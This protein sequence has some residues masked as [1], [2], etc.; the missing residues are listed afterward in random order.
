MYKKLKLELNLW[1][2]GDLVLNLHRRFRQ[3][4]FSGILFHHVFVDEVQDFTQAELYLVLSLCRDPD[5]CFLAGD[6]A[7][8]IARGVG[9]RFTDIK[10]IFHG[11]SRAVPDTFTLVHNYRSH[12]G[13]LSLAAAVVDVIYSYFP[14]A[15]DKLE[16]DQGLFPG[17]KPKLLLVDSISNLSALLLG[18]QRRDATMGS[19]EFGAQ[20]VVLVRSDAV[21]SQMPKEFTDSVIVLTVFE[22]KGL[23]FDDVLLWNFFSDG[24]TD[25]EWRTVYSYWLA[26]KECKDVTD[27]SS[28]ESSTN[29]GSLSSSSGPL[30]KVSLE[31]GTGEAAA[32]DNEFT[33]S[34]VF[35]NEGAADVQAASD[36]AIAL[37][38]DFDAAVAAA[39]GK[40]PVRPLDFDAEKHKVLESELKALY[41]AITRARVNVWIVD[42]DLKKRKPAFAWFAESSLCEVVQESDDGLLDTSSSASGSASSSSRSTP[43]EWLI[44]G[45]YFLEE[46]SRQESKRGFYENAVTC[47]R[48]AEQ[49][50]LLAKAVAQLAEHDAKEAALQLSS[51]SGSSGG[52]AHRAERLKRTEVDHLFLEAAEKCLEAKLGR[53][54]AFCLVQGKDDQ[55]AAALYRT[56]AA[57][58]GSKELYLRAAK[59][60]TR[61]KRYDDSI[62]LLWRGGYTA[63]AVRQ[64]ASERR[65]EVAARLLD[66][67]QNANL[68]CL[69]TPSASS[70]VDVKVQIAVQQLS[71][72]AAKDALTKGNRTQLL[73][74]LRVLPVLEQVAFL[75]SAEDTS[76]AASG[77]SSSTTSTTSTTGSGT[78]TSESLPSDSTTTSNNES[79]GYLGEIIAVLTR[80]GMH[81][82]AAAQCA[83][84]GEH[85]RG[86]EVLRRANDRLLHQAAPVPAGPAGESGDAASSRSISNNSSS[87]DS[88]GIESA[89][90]AMMADRGPLLEAESYL[91]FID[92]ALGCAF[93]AFPESDNTAANGGAADSISSSEIDRGVQHFAKGAWAKTRMG[94]SGTLVGLANGGST[95]T[96]RSCGLSRSTSDGANPGSWIVRLFDGTE[97]EVRSRDLTGLASRTGLKGLLQQVTQL[98]DQQSKDTTSTLSKLAAAI[99]FAAAVSGE[100]SLVSVDEVLPSTSVSESGASVGN[101]V[102]YGNEEEEQVD[103][104]EE[105]REDDSTAA[106]SAAAKASA[107][108]VLALVTWRRAQV[109][110]YEAQLMPSGLAATAQ[111]SKALEILAQLPDR[112]VAVAS[113]A[114]WMAALAVFGPRK[115]THG[116]GGEGAT[117]K[118]VRT[119]ITTWAAPSLAQARAAIRSHA[120]PAAVAL[121]RALVDNPLPPNSLVSSLSLVPS[122]TQHSSSATAGS[123]SA[124]VMGLVPESA[125]AHLE[126]VLG[127]ESALVGDPSASR[128]FR[129]GHKLLSSWAPMAM[130]ALSVKDT[131]ASS[132]S[133]TDPWS[134]APGRGRTHLAMP[135]N[136]ARLSLSLWLACSTTAFLRAD[137]PE[138]WPDH[139]TVAMMVADATNDSNIVDDAIEHVNSVELVRAAPP[140]ST[141]T[142]D[143]ALA[144]AKLSRLDEEILVALRNEGIVN[145]EQL[146]A[147]S[148]D[149]LSACGV[150]KGPYIK[151]KKWRANC[152]NSA[153]AAPVDT[154]TNG[155]IAAAV[156]ATPS[157]VEASVPSAPA[158]S[159][160]VASQKQLSV[161]PQ[162]S[163]T[164]AATVVEEAGQ[165][166]FDVVSIGWE[167]SL[168][169]TLPA[170]LAR[171]AL[172]ESMM[173]PMRAER[174]DSGSCSAFLGVMPLQASTARS[175]GNATLAAVEAPSE[176]VVE[177]ESVVAAAAAVCAGASTT[178]CA[179]RL[180]LAV[181]HLGHRTDDPS[182]FAKALSLLF[183]EGIGEEG[184]AVREFD[185]ESTAMATTSWGGASGMVFVLCRALD[186]P[187]EECRHRSSLC[188]PLA[189]SRP[190]RKA[191]KASTMHL[192][193]LAKKATGSFSSDELKLFKASV[194]APVHDLDL[195]LLAWHVSGLRQV[196]HPT[197]GSF[198]HDF[199]VR[200]ADLDGALRQ[201][202]AGHVP[203]TTVWHLWRNANVLFR[204]GYGGDGGER[205]LLGGVHLMGTLIDRLTSATAASVQNRAD[206][207][208]GCNN[209][210]A[211]PASRAFVLQRQASIL[212]ALGT[213]VDFSLDTREDTT[214]PFLWEASWRMK[215]PSLLPWSWVHAHLEDAPLQTVHKCLHK[216]PNHDTWPL[217]LRADRARSVLGCLEQLLVS[218]WPLDEDSYELEEA[219]ELQNQLAACLRS[220]FLSL[221]WALWW[222]V[223]DT[224]AALVSAVCSCTNAN[225]GSSL[226]LQCASELLDFERVLVLVLTVIVNAHHLSNFMGP[227]LKGNEVAHEKCSDVELEF[228][229]P[230]SVLGVL[231]KSFRVA[232]QFW[233]EALLNASQV[234]HA[235]NFAGSIT[236][237]NATTT[238]WA[239]LGSSPVGVGLKRSPEILALTDAFSCL[240]SIADAQGA[241][242]CELLPVCSTHSSMNPLDMTWELQLSHAFREKGFYGDNLVLSAMMGVIEDIEDEEIAHIK[243]LRNKL[244]AARENQ[245][246]HL[247]VLRATKEAKAESTTATPGAA[248]TAAGAAS[249]GCT[250]SANEFVL[251]AKDQVELFL[252][253]RDAQAVIDAFREWG[254][255]VQVDTYSSPFVLQ[256]MDLLCT[257]YKDEEIAAT[258]NLLVSLVNED[259]LTNEGVASG[260]SK[261]CENLKDYVLDVPKAQ[262]WMIDVI[263]TLCMAQV[264]DLTWLASCGGLM[265][266]S[267]KLEKFFGFSTKFA[268]QVL[269]AIAKKSDVAT[270]IGLGE[271][272]DLRTKAEDAGALDALLRE[273]GMGELA[274]DFKAK[275]F[276][277][278]YKALLAM[279][280]RLSS[281][282]VWRLQLSDASTFSLESAGDASVAVTVEAVTAAMAQAEID[283]QEAPFGMRRAT[284]ARNHFIEDSTAAAVVE[285]ERSSLV[286]QRSEAGRF[287][288]RAVLVWYRARAKSKAKALQDH[289]ASGSGS[290]TGHDGDSIAPVTK[291]ERATQ[292]LADLPAWPSST[293]GCALCG[294]YWPKDV[295]AFLANAKQRF[296]SLAERAFG[297]AP[298]AA[299]VSDVLW[300]AEP[301]KSTNNNSNK[302]RF[303]DHARTRNQAKTAASSSEISVPLS[304]A[305][306]AANALELTYQERCGISKVT[307]KFWNELRNYSGSTVFRLCQK[308]DATESALNAHHE[309][310]IK[311][312]RAGKGRAPRGGVGENQQSAASP[313][314]LD[315]EKKSLL[316]EVKRLHKE[317]VTRTRGSHMSSPGHKHNYARWRTYSHAEQGLC[318][319]V[320]HAQLFMHRLPPADVARAM[321]TLGVAIEYQLVLAARGRNYKAL[322]SGNGKNGD[323]MV[324][325]LNEGATHLH[326][327][328]A[329][330]AA[331][332]DDSVYLWNGG[333]RGIS[334]GENG[335]GAEAENESDNEE[336]DDDDGGF[337][338]D[339]FTLAPAA[340]SKR[341]GGKARS[342]TNIP[343]SG[344]GEGDG[345]W[346]TVG[347][348]KTK[349]SKSSQKGRS[350][351]GLVGK[352][353]R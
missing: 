42:F 117:S 290:V 134:P 337:D 286:E 145:G 314:N 228:V 27:P 233:Q 261:F 132:S 303:L 4:G 232:V 104:L 255:P 9:F 252:A 46:A 188:V 35:V 259:L 109:L 18:H 82:E 254:T 282:L 347:T 166:G 135:R 43:E 336:G 77:G 245:M 17:P 283:G 58:T 181:T 195:C 54:A 156:V 29:S 38:D 80:A 186:R 44:R 164:T 113:T 353:R 304:V 88:S 120:C 296:I 139:H 327:L 173:L 263:S 251:G 256:L 293:H 227:P 180:L 222:E 90:T 8:T 216:H 174:R 101:G 284:A 163:G 311:G 24:P 98:L 75:Q 112:I 121:A 122:S 177:P 352:P 235:S 153:P 274:D 31:E 331:D 47:F 236:A 208:R 3:H 143:E 292:L 161:H 71:R 207:S 64:A 240:A 223:Q 137:L 96:S 300:E 1:D 123:T 224:G 136:A 212:M 294:F 340:A 168:A 167:E 319:A 133:P 138:K 214:V 12:R 141:L 199:D 350:R 250:L 20:Q 2:G 277:G 298:W 346:I 326:D 268:V 146:T 140:L 14:G 200:L 226:E 79:V 351:G 73:S 129:R 343:A 248:A 269:G 201:P 221:A 305:L 184:A 160:T 204:G 187:W 165:D 249:T 348:K 317:S 230:E 229:L 318:A 155:G 280:E 320:A 244:N 197:G 11:M 157:S 131:N 97:V 266:E 57:R 111:L 107:E 124:V 238:M 324:S 66:L 312:N 332:L 83:A 115:K 91:R 33:E 7:Q 189:G 74:F 194:T 62:E 162:D 60:Y 270:A 154:A 178:A 87:S 329:Q 34:Q 215:A 169:S 61:L 279:Q 281:P 148:E 247:D 297:P 92:E 52:G 21:R 273:A 289:I 191:K 176:A 213:M 344:N 313:A 147:A 323:K 325:T 19:I 301:A 172:L 338:G 36:T 118:G 70:T 287:L 39:T 10:D 105:V 127:L 242:L 40:T 93:P 37:D 241:G 72:L 100:A 144:Q 291:E 262:L 175:S 308:L 81:A 272:L 99:S 67:D 149:V 190:K 50:D 330:T 257:K 345:E 253:T 119:E 78:G 334:G 171:E 13:V 267:W 25:D 202:N 285:I 234:D 217:P 23:E 322:R 333:N 142:L 302:R 193:Y 276:K 310:A 65:F 32:E 49:P 41:C 108:E 125:C 306:K 210:A 51:K 103:N 179:E 76:L 158:D 114:N 237:T 170:R 94:Q 341:G 316:A 246:A 225:R 182:K 152:A 271:V 315:K 126:A 22:A 209:F 198:S 239:E 196:S 128:E 16:P 185:T 15:I 205:A 59:C 95:S 328:H 231:V 6:T 183:D 56:E 130:S 28:S 211:T 63:Q 339:Y 150:K 30:A 342:S 203:P 86:A 5:Q 335:A 110:Q 307:S 116:S 53:E 151:L 55:R 278:D 106:P 159:S 48:R 309:A 264:L 295:K 260:L 299:A 218:L 26:K 45:A 192:N 321:P 102:G 258:A 220:E 69:S 206:S 89:A 243:Q 84:H 275:D 288:H 265:A 68:S 85:L 349:R 219:Q